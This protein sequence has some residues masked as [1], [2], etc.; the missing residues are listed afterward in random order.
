MKA[1]IHPD[2][3]TAQVRCSCGNTFTTRSTSP[4]LH[5]SSAASATPSTRASR[6]WSTPVAASTASS[7]ATASASPRPPLTPERP[8]GGA[9]CRDAAPPCWRQVGLTV[10]RPEPVPAHR[11]SSAKLGRARRGASGAVPR[12]RRA[13]RGRPVPRGGAAGLRRRRARAVGCWSTTTPSAPSGPA[14]AW[15]RQPLDRGRD[16]HL[17]VDRHAGLLARRAAAFADPPRSGRSR[18]TRSCAA[19]GRPARRTPPAPP[20]AGSS[21]CVDAAREPR[22]RGG[23]R[24]R[25]GH[26]R[27]ARARGGPGGGRRRRSAPPRG[28]GR[29]QRPRGLRHHPRRS[30][31]RSRRC[32]GGATP[33]STHRRAGAPAHPLN[34]LGAPAVAAGPAGGRARTWSGAAEPDPGARRPAPGRGQGV[35]AGGR[36]GDRCRRASRWWWWRRP[37]STSTW[38]PP[39][40]ICAWPTRPGARLVLVVPERDAHPVTRRAGR[41][42][43]RAGR[44]GGAARRLARPGSTAR[45]A[46]APRVP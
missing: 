22:R 28:R 20:A 9:A 27:G 29:A 5:S 17:V 39:P 43:G 24:P 12:G 6:S 34:R 37:A 45:P 21:S 8:R 7:A 25:R 2:Y 16:L 15:A 31:P 38:C 46:T 35:G 18:A 30:G 32:L 14:M 10:S 44:G 42:A 3:V 36:G 26:R 40:P 23:D 13:S 11:C 41:R 1:D 33:S 4:E 19:V